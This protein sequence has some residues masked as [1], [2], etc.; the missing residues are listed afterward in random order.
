MMSDRIGPM[1]A[2]IAAA[3]I[4]FGYVHPTWT[5]TIAE[6]KAAIAAD[7]E[8]LEAASAYKAK[9]NELAAARNAIDPESLERLNVFLPDSVDNVGMILDLNALASRSGIVLSNIDVATEPTSA[10]VPTRSAAPVARANPIGSID[11]S[12]SAVGTYSALQT[13]LMGIERSARILDVRELTVRG[14]DTGVYTYQMKIRIYWL[15]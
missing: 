13:F 6:S 5:V 4:F 3:G 11:L 12:L 8:A 7:D 15:R 14:S 2:F 1:F 9:Q 10:T